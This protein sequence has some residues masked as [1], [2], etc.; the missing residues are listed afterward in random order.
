VDLELVCSS[1]KEFKGKSWKNCEDGCVD[2]NTEITDQM[3]EVIMMKEYNLTIKANETYV[4]SNDSYS[5]GKQIQGQN[6]EYGSTYMYIAGVLSV[7]FIC[8]L[9]GVFLL[10]RLKSRLSRRKCSAERDS[11]DYNCEY[12]KLNF[13]GNSSGSRSVSHLPELTS[14]T[15]DTQDKVAV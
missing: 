8:L 4:N 10:H 9:I 6:T 7:T 2:F 12:T 13:T 15:Q 1:P 14:S 5:F 11:K 3:E